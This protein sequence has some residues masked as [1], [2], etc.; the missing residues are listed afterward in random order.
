M[1]CSF[2]D[3]LFD[4]E[5]FELSRSGDLVS[6]EPQAFE[7]LAYLVAHRD[8]VVPREEL[9]SEVWG[10][11]FVSDSA[12]ATRIKEARRAIGDDGRLQSTIR[13]VHGRGYRFVAEVEELAA[14]AT[15]GASVALGD[16]ASEPVAA[17][18]SAGGEATRPV[19]SQEIRFCRAPDG[20]NLAHTATG[21]GPALVKAANWLTHLEYDLTSPVWRHVIEDL[22]AD[23]QLIRY[24][25]RGN[26]LSDW[27]VDEWSFEAWVRDLETVVDARG[28]ER[29][30][31]FGISQ[32]GAVAIAYAAR[33]PERVSHLILHGS[34]ARGRRQP[35]P[36]Q[37]ASAEAL[38]TLTELG[39][40]HPESAFGELFSSMMLGSGS[41][42]QRQWLTDL[43]R[44]STSAENAVQ[45]RQIFNEIDIEDLIPEVST[46]ALVTHS[47]DDGMVPFEEGRRLAVYLPN[48]RLVPLESDNHLLLEH[49]PAWQVFH[50]EV[51][52]F[53]G[54]GA[55]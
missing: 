52:S 50:D 8:R 42:E 25:E 41:A 21:D 28:L 10:S 27:D 4:T 39:W 17:A 5:R 29:F 9:L 31:L 43:Q 2:G 35:D 49:E 46:P 1:R 22:S 33:H 30:A 37:T 14:A 11:T 12:L 3:Y 44:V 36:E 54:V 16:Q 23:H 51:R 32:G 38:R 45:F 24:D 13:T 53:L 34:Y 7:V 18:N 47:K 20:V 40:G 15:S 55:G 6:V 48:A 26:G 19:L